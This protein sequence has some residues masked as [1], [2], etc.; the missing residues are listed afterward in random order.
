MN[1][2]KNVVKQWRMTRV[3][4]A[5][6]TG[7]IL[8][9]ANFAMDLVLDYFGTTGAETTFNDVAIGVVGAIAVFFFLSATHEKQKFADAKKR[10]ALL[11]ELNK[12]IRRTFGDLA[13]SAM[14][15]DRLTRL[16]GIDEVSERMDLI[17][18]E[19]KTDN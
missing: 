2:S 4:Y 7:V 5:L 1:S 15:E 16:R 19:L 10:I 18:S 6:M 12:D 17:L 9:F 14:S 8:C 11:A 13:V 3:W